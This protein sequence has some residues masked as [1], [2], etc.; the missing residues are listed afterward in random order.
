MDIVL[1]QQNLLSIRQRAADVEREIHQLAIDQNKEFTRQFF[2]AGP[3]DM[4]RKL[5]AFRMTFDS[6]GH[7]K[8]DVGQGGFFSM[9]PEM[10]G[11]YGMLNPQYNPHMIELKREQAELQEFLKSLKMPDFGEAFDKLLLGIGQQFADVMKK[12]H[13]DMPTESMDAAKIAVD[14]LAGSSGHAAEQLDRLA[15]KAG[16]LADSIF[17]ASVFHSGQAAVPSLPQGGGVGGGRGHSN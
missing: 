8:P 1:Q 12:F 14:R 2:G 9:G 3:A 10:R 7:R 17:G 6:G 13:T 5:A 16:R 4:L 11:D 15:E